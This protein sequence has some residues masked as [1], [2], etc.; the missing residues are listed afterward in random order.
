MGKLQKI[1]EDKLQKFQFR[2]ARVI[3]GATYNIRSADVL[4]TLSGEILNARRLYV[5]S[6]FIYKILNNYTAP[7]LKESVHKISEYENTYNLRNTNTDL[8]LPQP[9]KEFLKKSFRYSGA[10][11]WNYLT[12]EVK[13]AESLNSFKRLIAQT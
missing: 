1:V 9:K 4:E 13:Q 11:L 3:T 5:K 6:V 8:A 10:L 12:Y 2:A 7:T